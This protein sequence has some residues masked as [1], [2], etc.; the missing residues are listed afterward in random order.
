M[1][2]VNTPTKAL[3]GEKGDAGIIYLY[4]YIGKNMDW[5]YDEKRREENI[6]DVDIL[7]HIQAFEKEGKKELHIRINSPGGISSHAD[8]I[9]NMMGSTKMDVHTFNDG[10]AASCA[11][12]LFLAAKKENRHMA[13]NAKLMIHATSIYQYGNAKKLRETAD[14]LDKYDNAA[15]K[16]MAADTGM[17]ETDIRKLYYEDGHDHWFTAD[18]AVKIGFVSKVADYEVENVIEHPEKLSHKEL[19]RQ[20]R[21]I[22]PTEQQVDGW[23]SKML[24]RFGLVS[25]TKA[26]IPE[27]TKSTQDMT[28]EELKSSIADGTLKIAD[29]VETVKAHDYK[30][31]KVEPPKPVG[32]FSLEDIT[33]AINTAVEPMKTKLEAIEAENKALKVQI[34][35]LEDAPGANGPSGVASKGDATG[36]VD[37]EK[38]AYLD[39]RKEHGDYARRRVNPYAS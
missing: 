1:K 6:T 29:V 35:K 3:T 7:R 25:P 13:K 12:D 4:G 15:I 16:Q 9:I 37:A 39:A 5:T 31:E 17:K 18:D 2:Q 10:T 24:N 20:F 14:M 36:E 26:A 23:F 22:E 34:T 8:A 33:K 11:A 21:P 28:I 19:V 32:A 30:V 38:K 27:P